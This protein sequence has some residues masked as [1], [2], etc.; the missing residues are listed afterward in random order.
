LIFM[1]A[2]SLAE[3]LVGLKM[4]NPFKGTADVDPPGET[5]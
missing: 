2:A 4:E 1:G 5:A 3:K